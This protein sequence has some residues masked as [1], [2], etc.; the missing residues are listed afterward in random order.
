MNKSTNESKIKDFLHF[1]IILLQQKRDFFYKN[2]AEVLFSIIVR[3]IE[4]VNSESTRE[5]WLD[6]LKIAHGLGIFD[7]MKGKFEEARRVLEKVMDEEKG[8]NYNKAKEL[9][10]KIKI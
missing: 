8:N 9:I 7:Q 1:L 5:K 10:D 4:N 6:L 3:E 2:D